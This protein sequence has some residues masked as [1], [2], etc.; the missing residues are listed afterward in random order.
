M[1]KTFLLASLVTA[2]NAVVAD[3]GM[4]TLENFPSAIVEEKY[5]AKITDDW[6]DAI[7]QSVARLDNGC[8]ASFVSSSG[9]LLTNHHCALRCIA[10]NSSAQED[11]ETSGYL[12]K[13]TDEELS[14]P[15]FMLSV[16]I[17][18]TDIT[19]SVQ[20]GIA[21]SPAVDADELLGEMGIR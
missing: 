21:N 7:R 10:G 19:D 5:G 17:D 9:V 18:A 16:L 14:C 12:A 8:S 3:E 1:R 15:S 13:T 11:L 2:A 4:W 20:A 6:L